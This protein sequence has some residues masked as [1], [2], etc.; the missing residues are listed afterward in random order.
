MFSSTVIVS[1]CIECTGPSV[2]CSSRL[3][4]ETEVWF[5]LAKSS[6]KGRGAAVQ[7][8]YNVQ[9]SHAVPV[10]VITCIITRAS[11]EGSQRFNNTFS[12]FMV[13]SAE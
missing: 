8:C 5:L 12:W 2:G 7:C 10:C 9:C 11:N 1:S 13:E 4:P 6:Q 3:Q